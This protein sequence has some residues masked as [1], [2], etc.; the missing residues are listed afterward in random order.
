MTEEDERTVHTLWVW[1]SATAGL[2]IGAGAVVRACAHRLRERG[3]RETITTVLQQLN[4]HGG[5]ATVEDHDGGSW[6]VRVPRGRSAGH[7]G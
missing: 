7:G 6:T 1:S 5:T 2:G 4:V 3:R